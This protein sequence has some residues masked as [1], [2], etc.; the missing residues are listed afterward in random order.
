MLMLFMIRSTVSIA[1]VPVLT[2]GTAGHDAWIA[3]VI[4]VLGTA[5]IVLLIGGL[6]I[7]FEDM[8][9]VEYSVELL[10]KPVGRVVS[11][12]LVF[13]FL[14]F[15][16]TDVRIYSEVL[17]T[18][19][20][21]DAP[22]PFIISATVLLAAITVYLGIEPLGRMADMLAPLFVLFIALGIIGCIM[23]FDVRNLEPILSRGVMPVLQGALSPMALSGKYLTLAMLIP[24]TTR[25]SKAM[26]SAL[27]SAVLA[28][29]VLISTSIATISVL[30]ADLSQHTVFPF[31]KALRSIQISRILQRVEVLAAVSWGF[32]LYIDLSLF[33]YCGAKGLAQILGLDEHRMLITPLAVIWA[34]Y[35]IGSYDTVFEL[36]HTYRPEALVPFVATMILL[37]YTV[38]WVAYIVRTLRSRRKGRVT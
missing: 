16:A 12:L 37:P 4:V 23:L 15:A 33:L 19:F 28:G 3:S 20:T 21:P 22:I 8:T 14:H 1:T 25:P 10:G 34:T 9:V 26:V 24:N 32:G 13:M 18:E 36:M 7:K 38:L 30:G 11:S 6:G 5:L 31:F 27:V 17:V 2:Q 29:V 35:A